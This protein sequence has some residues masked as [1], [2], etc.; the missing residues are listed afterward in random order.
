MPIWLFAV[1]PTMVRYASEYTWAL[2]SAVYEYD[3]FM[4]MFGLL[5]VSFAFIM[6]AKTVDRL[7]A[8]CSDGDEHR[9]KL[10]IG[11]LVF[12]WTFTGFYSS[13]H[14]LANRTRLYYPGTFCYVDFNVTNDITGKINVYSYSLLVFFALLLIVVLNVL[15]L[16]LAC[17][18]LELRS[19]LTD[20]HRISGDT[21][22]TATCS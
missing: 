16:C 9:N 6:C 10:Y 7:K 18:N 17:R 11:I 20:R 22:G 15:M 3:S 19:R 2:P 13:L 1:T 14:L 8:M 21:S 4:H 12:I 5:H